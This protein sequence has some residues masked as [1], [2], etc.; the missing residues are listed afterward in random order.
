[1]TDYHLFP[2]GVLVKARVLPGN[3][4]TP[5]KK[6]FVDPRMRLVINIG[7]ECRVGQVLRCRRMHL[8]LPALPLDGIDLL[9]AGTL[10]HIIVPGRPP[11][12]SGETV[13]LTPEM[14]ASIQY[15]L[16]HGYLSELESLYQA[17]VLRDYLFFPAG[18]L[19]AGK[20]KPEADATPMHRAT[21]LAYF[22][23]M[24]ELAGVHPQPRR[25]WYGLR[26]RA[27]DVAR[28][29][30]SDAKVLNAQGGWKDSRTRE[31]IYQDPDNEEVKFEAARVRRAARLGLPT[32]EPAA[33]DDQK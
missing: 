33:S 18:R 25:G 13:Y 27:T 7:A 32:G 21:A 28:R 31:E 10:G 9:P 19:V 4:Q 17:G 22:H 20:A 23:E 30:S 3:A 2:R 1:M 15:A 6:P 11:K 14:Y 8:S 26:R 29:Y 5:F 12:K 16:T 24:E